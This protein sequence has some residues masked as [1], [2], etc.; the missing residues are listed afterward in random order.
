M[1]SYYS[2]VAW[3]MKNRCSPSCGD[4]SADK[5]DNWLNN[6]LDA[7]LVSHKYESK[8]SGLNMARTEA[9]EVFCNR[10]T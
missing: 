5:N 4:S 3:F 10:R 8:M 6:G 9:P 1:G 2:F 7:L